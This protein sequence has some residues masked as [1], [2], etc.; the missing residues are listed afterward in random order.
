M[1]KL[2]LSM[3]T[4]LG[5]SLSLCA[6]AQTAAS[7]SQAGHASLPHVVATNLPGVYAF[8]QPPAGFDPLTASREDLESWGYPPRPDVAEGLNAQARWLEAVNPALRRSV[9][10]LVSRPNSYNRQL[11]GLKVNSKRFNT[12]ASTS[13]NWS[14]FALVSAATGEQPFSKVAGRWTV[15]TVKQAPGSCSGGWD[16]SS[17]WVGIGGFSDQDLLQ[18]GS[19]ANVFCDIGNNIA[20]YFPWVEWLP[21]E[22]LVLYEDAATSTLYPFAPG[23]Y[24]NVTIAATNFSSGVSTSGTLSF[25][26]VTQGW[27]IALTFTAS[28]LGGSKVTGQSAEWIVERTEVDDALA[29]LPDYVADPWAFTQATDLGALTYTPGSPRTAT[30]YNITMLDNSNNPESFVDM[31]G[32]DGLWFFPEGSAVK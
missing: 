8:T 21:S 7:T 9:P 2:L 14:G 23:D 15:P 26:D 30:A 16:Y 20:E 28:S 4:I 22:E 18:A 3:I 29:T 17:E 1:K 13:D 27:S 32:S 24:L 11:E 12:T 5:L 25:A 10:D 6:Q 31:F 19:A